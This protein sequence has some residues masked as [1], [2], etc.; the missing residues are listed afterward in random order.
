[1]KSS[2]E[3]LDRPV[4]E[5]RP[6]VDHVPLR[7]LRRY[8]P[9]RA[10][11]DGSLQAIAAVVADAYGVTIDQMQGT[12][13]K[14]PYPRQVAMYFA[15]ELTDETVVSIGAYFHR[16]HTCVSHSHQVVLDTVSVYPELAQ[17][18]SKLRADIERVL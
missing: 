6:V 18:L 1:M 13:R 5:I 16:D 9:S 4:L 14:N 11:K 15:R 10:K 12:G 17:E 8:L 7:K 2:L 3:A